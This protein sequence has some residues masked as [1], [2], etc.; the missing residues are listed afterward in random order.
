MLLGG[1]CATCK[2]NISIRYPFVEV[3]NGVI[4]VRCFTLFPPVYG[5]LSAL[6]ATI[7]ITLAWIDYQTMFIPLSLVISGLILIISGLGLGVLDWQS[8]LWGAMAGVFIPLTMMGI[9]Y[10]ITKRQ[11]M[12]WG[13]IQL[14]LILGAWLGPLRIILTL[15]I[16]AA[17]ALLV[18]VGISIFKGFDKNRPLPFAPYLVAG[19]LSM[20]LLSPYFGKLFDKYLLL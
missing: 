1:K 10:I 12:G 8:A 6:F 9:T 20:I 5:G 19:A 14:G 17:L 3:L 13:D 16:A 4:W 2:K 18:W 7:L 15:F 11:G